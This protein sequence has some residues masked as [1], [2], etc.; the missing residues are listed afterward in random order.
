MK[1]SG[2]YSAMVW[3]SRLPIRSAIFF[4]PP[5]ATSIGIC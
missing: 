5:N 1:A 4:G 3:G 2:S